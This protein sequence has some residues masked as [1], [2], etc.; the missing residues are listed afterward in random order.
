MVK[1]E[2]CFNFFS[3]KSEFLKLKTEVRRII[4]FYSYVIFSSKKNVE[5]LGDVALR[6]S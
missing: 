3:E 1:T 4:V 5:N 6:V 2:F